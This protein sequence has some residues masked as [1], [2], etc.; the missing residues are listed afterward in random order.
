MFTL[1]AVG[2]FSSE[3]RLT[4]PTLPDSDLAALR[5]EVREIIR[6][7]CGS[8]HTSTLPTAKPKAVAVFDLKSDDW[9]AGMTAAQLKGFE[10]RLDKFSESEKVK[11]GKLLSEETRNETGSGSPKTES[12]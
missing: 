10:K 3:N 9:S 8:C 2:L 11:I 5:K 6:P 1:A 12:R 7:S 4:S